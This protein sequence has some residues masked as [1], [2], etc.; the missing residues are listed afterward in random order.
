VIM[1]KPRAIPA[2]IV[3]NGFGLGTRYAGCFKRALM[4]AALCLAALLPVTTISPAQAVGT[5]TYSYDALGRLSSVDYGNGVTITY[6]YDA[7][8]NRT[9]QVVNAAVGGG[10]IWSA[11]VTPCTS[12][13]WGSTVWSGTGDHAPVA[14]GDSLSSAG[15][16]TSFDPRTNDN[17][18]DGYALTITSVGTPSHGT[19]SINGGTSITYTPTSGYSGSDSFTYTISDGHGGTATA[20]VSVT[21]TATVNPPPT[22]SFSAS[23]ATI[24][25][26][27]SST[28]SWVG[29]NATSASI[30]NGVGS[31]STSGG[32]V[33]VSPST[34]TTYT[35]TLTGS[36][37]TITKQVVV[38]VTA[39]ANHP[40][41]ANNISVQY[42]QQSPPYGPW[43][44]TTD[45]RNYD[46]D[47]DGD[48]LSVTSV[49]TA[50]GCTISSSGP[51]IITVATASPRVT[52]TV[53]YTI[54]DGNGNSASA[55]IT[56]HQ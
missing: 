14:V 30:D 56:I 54:S 51:M 6:A 35:L 45:V 17:D 33:S 25:Q 49:G 5:A 44:A 42:F 31:V 34:T 50:P 41:V 36:G 21:V 24:N 3:L 9:S 12:N 26:G 19:A 10:L 27:S 18:P 28:L 48:T 38:T 23:P 11:A 40:P 46:S 52:C 7:S 1:Y 37:G 2:N 43:M 39:P 29:S 53:P 20:T 4:I 47:P 13:C 15:V 32:S 8:G 55:Y 16:A 22:G